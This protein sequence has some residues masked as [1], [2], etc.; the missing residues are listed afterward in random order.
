MFVFAAFNILVTIP[1]IWVFFKE[2]KL[3]SL[4]EIDLLFGERALGTLPDNLA[5]KDPDAM[6]AEG[7][8]VEDL[9]S[10]KSAR[11]EMRE[12]EHTTA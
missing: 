9:N 3:K 11:V 12:G 7:R 10:G 1:V 6:I 4:E 8:H 5:E 2:T